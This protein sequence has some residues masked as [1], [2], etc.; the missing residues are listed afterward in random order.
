MKNFTFNNILTQ[1]E[2]LKVIAKCDHKYKKSLIKVGDKKL[3]TAICDCVYNT[4]I[5]NVKLSNSDKE[6]LYKYRKHMYKLIR[7]SSLKNKK[8]LLI[9]TVNQKGG[10][11]N[12]LIQGVLAAAPLIIDGIS[13]LIKSSSVPQESE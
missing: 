12:L 6:K 4:L 7:K 1:K 2:L 13:S 8:E 3:I 9:K 10:F 5:G 11:L